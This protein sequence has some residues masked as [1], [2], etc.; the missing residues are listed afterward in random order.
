MACKR[1]GYKGMARNHA[2]QGP[3]LPAVPVNE[4]ACLCE[5]NKA[6]CRISTALFRSIFF[7]FFV[8]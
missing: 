8:N 2:E 6:I 5:G 7:N 3:L 1:K 4:W